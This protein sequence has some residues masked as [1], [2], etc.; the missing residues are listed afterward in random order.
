MN[1][2]LIGFTPDPEKMPAMAAK[3]THSKTK[4]E[5]LYKTSDKELKAIL[6]HVMNLGH[7]SVI[8]H[9]S[10]TFAISGV[11]RSLT[12]Q[13]VRHRIAS[14]AQQSERYNQFFNEPIK[15]LKDRN[16]RYKIQKK[17]RK[18]CKFSLGYEYRICD[19]YEEGASSIELSGKYDCNSETILNILKAHS[20]RVRGNNESVVN[21]Y[22]FDRIDSHIKAQILGVLFADGFIGES[23]KN[24]FIGIKLQEIDKEYLG[25]FRKII[26]LKRPLHFYS[27]IDEKH[28]NLYQL[29]ISS[30]RMYEKLK[31]YGMKKGKRE[32]PL[33]LDERLLNSFIL[34]FFEGDGSVGSCCGSKKWL[35]FTSAS[36]E[37][38][39]FIKK[40]IVKNCRVN[41]VNILQK[42]TAFQL[43]WH[44]KNDIDTILTWM[45]K[46]VCI[47][48]VMKRKFYKSC[49][50]YRNVDVIR[51]KLVLDRCNQ[52]NV[53]IP[54]S[55][56]QNI[57]ASEVFIKGV[58][59]LVNSYIISC[60]MGIESEDSR[61]ILPQSFKSNI[62]V[63]MNARSLL[64]FFELR[65]CLSAQWEIRKL[66]NLML[67]EV[68][69]KA[70][71]IFKNAGPACKT[72]GIC[73]E[74][75]KDCPLYP[76]VRN[77]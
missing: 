38:L 57:N 47:D 4:P 66:A 53:V 36:K 3:L 52:C 31:K 15:I 12:H 64:N 58:N 2:K 20:I 76:K 60:G 26:N 49:E 43:S 14:Y 22:F 41:N 63:T 69:K 46:D 1:V 21:H 9:T 5:D 29:T 62:I 68:K 55:I 48:F 54:P 34:G 40:I 18:E 56:L 33:F 42:K 19:E 7:T 67:N 44:G 11:S 35:T 10:F 17:R 45:Y 51:R 77:A 71:T 25:N 61:F 65:C 74:N 50:L 13:L 75:K 39:E 72:K 37:F 32:S 28:Q 23:K 70:P 27:A 6:K 8:E 16:D 24:Y 30:K 73:P 59:T